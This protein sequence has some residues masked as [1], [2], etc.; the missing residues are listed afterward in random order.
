MEMLQSLRPSVCSVFAQ[1]FN[2]TYEQLVLTDQ[3][4]WDDRVRWGR[5]RQKAGSY[6]KSEYHGVWPES[7]LV[8]AEGLVMVEL[9]VPC[10]GPTSGVYEIIFRVERSGVQ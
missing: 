9:F 3:A 8:F 5:A 4:R 1:T 6:E 7:N 10:S 2:G